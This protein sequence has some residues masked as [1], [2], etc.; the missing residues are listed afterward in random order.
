MIMKQNEII[1]I[2]AI[3]SVT[4]ISLT[5]LVLLLEGNVSIKGNKN[6]AEVIIRKESHP[7]ALITTKDCIVG[8]ENSRPIECVSK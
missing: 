3:A 8:E 5:S 7:K 1:A 2:A 4:L 6:G